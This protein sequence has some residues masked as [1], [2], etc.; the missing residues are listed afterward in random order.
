MDKAQFLEDA[1]TLRDSQR[2]YFSTRDS[3]IFMSCKDMEKKMDNHIIEWNLSSKDE[4]DD[5][6][7]DTVFLHFI[8]KISRMRIAQMRFFSAMWYERMY[9]LES[10]KKAEQE[11][12]QCIVEL[13]KNKEKE[14]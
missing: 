9:W 3:D 13:E 2:L 11:V 14:E 7:A 10:A 1:A 5:L 12:D 8:I 4:L 6:V